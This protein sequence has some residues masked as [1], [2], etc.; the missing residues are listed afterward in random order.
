[1]AGVRV[2]RETIDR[3][4]L[5]FDRLLKWSDAINLISPTSKVDAWRRHI[6][7]SAQLF[8]YRDDDVRRWCDLGSGGGLPAVV[9]AIIAKELAP[10]VQFVLAES[11]KRKASFLRIVIE[12]LNL[13]AGVECGRIED[14]PGQEANLVS[15]RALA[16]LDLLLQYVELHMRQDGYALLMKGRQYA[17]EISAARQNWGFDLE[18]IGSKVD[19]DSRILRITQI[20]RMQGARK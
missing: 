11:D 15:A 18:V 12:E 13:N 2:S 8:A 1:M 9:N 17:N 16:P 7:D 14:L 10:D 6:I 3:L 5:Y 19:P 4:E 20:H